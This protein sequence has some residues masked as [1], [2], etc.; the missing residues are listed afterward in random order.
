MNKHNLLELSFDE[1]KDFCLS[2]SLP[3]YKSKQIWNW[4]Y[5]FGF[6]S[7][8]NMTNLGKS[9]RVL[10]YENSYIYRPV[11]ENVQK[12]IDGTIKW[13]IKLE[14]NSLIETVFIPQGKR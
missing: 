6:S 10:L 11:I 14:D 13:L 12:S 1:L 8:E 5:C 7:F 4:I 3:N 2:L 9:T